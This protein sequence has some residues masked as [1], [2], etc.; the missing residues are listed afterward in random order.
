MQPKMLTAHRLELVGR[1][2]RQKPA[3]VWGATEAAKRENRWGIPQTGLLLLSRQ[4]HKNRLPALAEP[5]KNYLCY[6]TRYFSAFCR[7]RYWALCWSC[8]CSA[9]VLHV[10]SRSNSGFTP[11]M[12][13]G[14]LE[15]PKLL[16][17]VELKRCTEK[18]KSPT[19]S[20][21]QISKFFSNVLWKGVRTP[22]QS[23]GWQ[24]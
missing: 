6:K 10:L 8:P 5:F 7:I 2:L 12:H 14:K 18:H 17:L 22:P 21:L 9:G 20:S 19:R 4:D 3:R 1:A 16:S 15:Y 13:N 11:P 23:I 24:L